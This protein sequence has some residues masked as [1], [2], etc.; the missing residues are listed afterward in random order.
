MQID[1]VNAG[2][3]TVLCNLYTD[4]RCIKIMMNRLDYDG[5]IRDGFFI[6]NG[7][8]QDSAGVWNTTLDYAPIP[9][10]HA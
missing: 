5:L 3:T 7:V 4:G 10:L 8:E 1:V 9:H 6:R 2:I